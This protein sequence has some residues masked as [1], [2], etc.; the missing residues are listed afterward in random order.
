MKAMP[1]M[2]ILYLVIFN[3]HRKKK[4]TPG[5]ICPISLKFNKYVATLFSHQTCGLLPVKTLAPTHD[6]SISNY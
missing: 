6:R 5:E 4:K 3:T 1:E 2:E